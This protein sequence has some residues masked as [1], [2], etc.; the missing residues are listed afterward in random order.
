[1]NQI[2]IEYNTCGWFKMYADV[3]NHE[4]NKINKKCVYQM[5]QLLIK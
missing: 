2:L 3:V 1:M 5:V 4:V